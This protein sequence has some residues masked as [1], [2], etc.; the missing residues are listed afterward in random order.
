MS[1]N[2]QIQYIIHNESNEG[3]KK[4]YSFGSLGSSTCCNCHVFV[5]VSECFI[6]ERYGNFGVS[7][8]DQRFEGE[9]SSCS[10]GL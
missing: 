3:I 7:T 1:L 2:S 9:T 5:S 10:D 6:S 8:D 4:V